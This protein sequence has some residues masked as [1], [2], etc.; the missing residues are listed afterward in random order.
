MSET[1]D[2]TEVKLAIQRLDQNQ[3]HA[4]RTLEQMSSSLKELVTLQ[5][6]HDVLRA[7]VNASKEA[8]NNRLIKIENRL[9]WA[10][11]LVIGAVILKALSLLYVGQ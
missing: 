3:Q 6:D 9:T 8:D 5:K 1:E 10:E 2:A 4:S 7:E 11:R